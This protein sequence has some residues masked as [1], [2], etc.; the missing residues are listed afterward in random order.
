MESDRNMSLIM[1][2]SVTNTIQRKVGT[3]LGNSPHVPRII[4]T[5]KSCIFTLSFRLFP[6]IVYWSAPVMKMVVGLFSLLL[7]ATYQYCALVGGMNS[8]S[9][10]ERALHKT[11]KGRSH[12][13][14][15]MPFKNPPQKVLS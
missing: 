14:M 9:C 12:Y 5:E 10:K 3:T 2:T 7:K 11:E 13:K 6:F 4:T 1:T 15:E 8:L